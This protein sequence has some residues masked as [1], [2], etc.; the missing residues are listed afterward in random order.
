MKKEKKIL[1]ENSV[2]YFCEN[3]VQIKNLKKKHCEKKTFNWKKK[4]YTISK[5]SKKQF[6]QPTILLL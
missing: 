6:A 4:D 3:F 2:Y 1:S 5:V